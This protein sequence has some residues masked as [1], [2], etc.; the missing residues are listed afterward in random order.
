MSYQSINF[1]QKFGLFEER[2]LP[3]VI[4]EMNGYQF[5]LVEAARRFRVAP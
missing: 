1:E 3:K 2:W 5:K 4:A